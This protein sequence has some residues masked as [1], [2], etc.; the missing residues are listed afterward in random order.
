MLTHINAI[1]GSVVS[2]KYMVPLLK[3]ISRVDRYNF[4]FLIFYRISQGLY[5]ARFTIYWLLESCLITSI[6]LKPSIDHLRSLIVPFNG[7]YVA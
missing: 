7:E 4:I 5:M 6:T 1:Y 3:F 2:K